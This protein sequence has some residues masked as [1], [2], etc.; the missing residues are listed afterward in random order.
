M[1]TIMDE[2]KTNAYVRNACVQTDISATPSGLAPGDN[3]DVVD[4]APPLTAEPLPETGSVPDTDEVVNLDMQRNLLSECNRKALQQRGEALKRTLMHND[5][6]GSVGKIVNERRGSS[7]GASSSGLGRTQV[8]ATVAVRE[9]VPGDD[10]T[11]VVTDTVFRSKIYDSEDEQ[12]SATTTTWG[13]PSTTPR[14]DPQAYAPFPPQPPPVEAAS[15]PA[16]LPASVPTLAS[17]FPTGI[18]NVPLPPAPPPFQLAASSQQQ[19]VQPF[20][21]MAINAEVRRNPQDDLNHINPKSMPLNRSAPLHPMPSR[22]IPNGESAAQAAPFMQP[23]SVPPPPTDPHHQRTSPTPPGTLPPTRQPPLPPQPPKATSLVSMRPVGPP[24]GKAP[25]GT[26]K[27]PPMV[28]LPKNGPPRV[29]HPK[30]APPAPFAMADTAVSNALQETAPQAAGT[31][32]NAKYDLGAPASVPAP[33]RPPPGP[34]PATGIAKAPPMPPR[35]QGPP[36]RSLAPIAETPPTGGS[37]NRERSQFEFGGPLPDS[38]LPKGPM[39]VLPKLPMGSTVD[40]KNEAPRTPPSPASPYVESDPPPCIAHNQ[41]WGYEAPAT[42]VHSSEPSQQAVAND[43]Q[44]WGNWNPGNNGV[45][46]EPRDTAVNNDIA[47]L[48]D[49]QAPQGPRPSRSLSRARP[50][51][52]RPR[53]T[54][55]VRQSDTVVTTVV[56]TKARSTWVDNNDHSRGAIRPSDDKSQ[57]PQHHR[58][59]WIQEADKDA[60]L[61][62]H[63]FFV[64]DLDQ[65]Y[66]L[67]GNKACLDLSISCA[68]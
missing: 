32:V 62:G 7:S 37:Q 58:P 67:T 40:Q 53:G 61:S 8:A 29:V 55:D 35:P 2:N 3:T 16:S 66:A 51:D 42:S 47:V 46:A 12:L 50:K 6:H 34:P 13:S 68:S 54:Y 36:P 23:P 5:V 9:T 56:V 25:P 22:P 31:H 60:R 39:P 19:L 57:K 45:W 43:D 44:S 59:P 30:N 11:I 63:K 21:Q 33:P 17:S 64:G 20:N 4:A 15:V 49:T 10:Q 24:A 52:T 48:H 27:A 65:K 1:H 28:I 26:P 38:S 14:N 41:Q 18:N